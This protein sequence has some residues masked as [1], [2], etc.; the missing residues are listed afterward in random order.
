M[1][2]RILAIMKTQTF[3]LLRAFLTA[4]GAVLV[5]FGLNDGHAW[6]PV[7]GLA[8]ATFSLGWGWVW[9]RDPLTPGRLSWSLVRKFVNALTAALATY[10]WMHPEQVPAVLTLFATLGPLM[11]AK[12][13]WIDNSDDDDAPGPPLYPIL[14]IFL[15]AS[16][17]PSCAGLGLAPRAVVVTL[18]LSP[19]K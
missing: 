8:L 7:I 17:L 10:G 5:T 19:D 4:L 13:S 15:A 12:F 16:F 1:P 14:I 9:H 6:L 11:A 18:T 3:G 2:H